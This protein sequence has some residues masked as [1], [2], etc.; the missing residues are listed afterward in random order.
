M[1]EMSFIGHTSVILWLFSRP[2]LLAD[3]I[4]S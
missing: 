1:Y 2:I 3:F 4:V